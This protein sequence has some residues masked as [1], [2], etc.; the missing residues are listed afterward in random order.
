[1][2]EM[3][4]Q[5]PKVLRRR[6]QLRLPAIQESP[7]YL[8]RLFLLL[9]FA[10]VVQTTL[11]PYITVLGAKPDAALIVVVVLAMM[12]G[13]VWGA[14]VGFAM[15]LLLDIALV[16]TMGVSSLLFTLAGYFSGRYAEGADPDAWLPPMV[17]VFIVTLV[18]QFLLAFI[19][20]LL[21]IE[22]SVEFVLLRV[23]LPVAIFNALLAVPVFVICRRWLGDEQKQ[24]VFSYKR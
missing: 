4:G 19:M 18:E 21:G 7:L 16:Q 2:A 9:V 12:R 24:R 13:P 15:G 23:V 3:P 5:Q 14:V 6:H 1:M 17:T 8:L 10:V 11:S 22:A 20:F